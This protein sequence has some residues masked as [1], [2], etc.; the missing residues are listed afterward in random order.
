MGSDTVYLSVR[1]LCSAS[2]EPMELKT[3]KP[4]SNVVLSLS[5]YDLSIE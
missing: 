2:L 5:C 1:F 4:L 3:Q